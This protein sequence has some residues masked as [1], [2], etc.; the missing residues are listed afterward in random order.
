MLRAGLTL[1]FLTALWG[2]ALTL[3]LRAEARTSMTAEAED[4]ES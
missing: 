4:I 3:H 1:V 2:H